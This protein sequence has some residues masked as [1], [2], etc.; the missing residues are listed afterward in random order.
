[1]T[2]LKLVGVFLLSSPLCLSAQAIGQSPATTKANPP[3]PQN[4]STF[5]IQDVSASPTGIS[6]VIQGQNVQV[7]SAS[8][9]RQDPKTGTNLP[10]VNSVGI[11]E[12]PPEIRNPTGSA[13]GTAKFPIVVSADPNTQ[14]T[15]TLWAK[16][17]DDAEMDWGTPQSRIFRGYVRPPS[18]TFKLE[19]S[20][21]SLNVSVETPEIKTVKAEWQLGASTVSTESNTGQ[22]PKV[23]LKYTALG[24]TG[25]ELPGLVLTLEDPKTHEVQES[26]VTLAVAADPNLKNKV[27]TAKADTAQ[28]QSKASFSWQDLAK[29]GVGALLTYFV[30]AL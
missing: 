1:M 20:A 10:V 17:G 22:N 23:A 28:K 30:A 21:D 11:A 2:N 9:D 26:R 14:Y 25:A 24:G 15:L 18:Q 12:V 29:T 8:I 19:F 27:K 4:L 5:N 7:L 13:I 6:V 16:S 3:K